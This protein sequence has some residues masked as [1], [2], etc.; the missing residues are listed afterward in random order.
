MAV[1]DGRMN[2]GMYV[3]FIFLVAG[4]IVNLFIIIWLAE[5]WQHE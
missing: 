1:G 3:L 5:Q 2:F 4:L